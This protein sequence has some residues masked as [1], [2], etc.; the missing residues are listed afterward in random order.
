MVHNGPTPLCCNKMAD[1]RADTY[2]N[3]KHVLLARITFK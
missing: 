2:D 3:L 1:S